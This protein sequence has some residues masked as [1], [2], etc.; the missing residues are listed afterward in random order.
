MVWNRADYSL[1][2]GMGKWGKERTRRT[3]VKTHIVAG[4]KT[5]MV[6]AVEAT[7]TESADAKQFPGLVSDTA[8][9]FIINEV[10]AD[11]AYSDRR[12]LN[13]VDAVGGTA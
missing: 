13:A 11:K 7:P 8:P 12:N 2:V 5:Y 1:K 10:S 3:W 9:N 4:T 6:T